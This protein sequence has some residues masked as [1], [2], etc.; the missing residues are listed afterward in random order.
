MRSA[1]KASGVDLASEKV[2]RGARPNAPREDVYRMEAEILQANP[3]FI[4]VVG[5][6]STIDAAKNP[7][8]SPSGEIDGGCDIF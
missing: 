8:L 3:S 5:S 1:L 7:Q 4:T 2:I 6:G